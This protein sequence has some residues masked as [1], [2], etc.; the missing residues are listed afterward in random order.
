M[1]RYAGLVGLVLACVSVR[2]QVPPPGTQP[3]PQVPAGAPTQPVLP[4]Q[5]SPLTEPVPAAQAAASG[6]LLT[7]ADC[8]RLALGRGFDLEIERQSLFIA[9][10]NV[11]IARS[12]FLPVL[13]ATTGKSVTR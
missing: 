7:L 12:T 3:V 11:P 13:S 5:V 8:I 4:G 1:R 2:A 6:P 9:Q 10:D